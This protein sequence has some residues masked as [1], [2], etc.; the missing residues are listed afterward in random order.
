MLSEGLLALL[1][2]LV[3]L[4]MIRVDFSTCGEL[5]S[6]LETMA[7]LD[8]V[9]QIRSHTELTLVSDSLL[10]AA[11]RTL[12]G[13]L[14]GLEPTRAKEE[15]LAGMLVELGSQE[16]GVHLLTLGV[17]LDSA[18]LTAELLNG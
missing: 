18:V 10:D 7:A 6:G 17:A 5:D 1:K 8:V 15:R 3:R 12:E 11:L 2:E 9:W 14:S 4:S 13:I 16:L